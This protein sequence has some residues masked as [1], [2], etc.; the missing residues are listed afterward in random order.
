MFLSNALA[1]RLWVAGFIQLCGTPPLQLLSPR[2]DSG[3]PDHYTD[4]DFDL[5][6]GAIIM[7]GLL[8]SAA[9]IDSWTTVTDVRTWAGV[10]GDVWA[11]VATALG[12]AELNAL[13]LVAG[14]TDE[15]YRAAILGAQP[16]ITPI[17]RVS[18]NLLF[19]GIKA[20]FGLESN[21]MQNPGASQTA[22]SSST[23]AAAPTTIAVTTTPKVRL[24]QV[25]DQAKDQEVPVLSDTII[26]ELRK[27]YMVIFRDAPLELVEVTDS[28]LTAFHYLVEN[29][30]APFTD[31]GVW[32]P[33]G[34]RLER[35]MRFK[36]HFLD[37][38][39]KWR[40][41]ELPGPSCIEVWRKC[42]RVFETAAIMTQAITPAALMRYA[43]RFEER[44]ER[45][46]EA[47]H[48]CVQADT[49][50][51]SEFLVA[52][53]R[54]QEDFHSRH[55]TVS[56]FNTAMP[57]DSVLKEAAD[58]QD[59]WNRELMEPALTYSRQRGSTPAP[60]HQVLTPVVE[61]SAPPTA[62][63]EKRPRGDRA[64]SRT[65]VAQQICHAF[66]RF[67]NGCQ[68]PCPSGRLHACEGC[69]TP[70]VRGIDC[71]F[72]PSANKRAKGGGKGKK[73]KK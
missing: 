72:K 5:I 54:R 41:T 34:A 39:G 14:L 20:K 38:E 15:D 11:R 26:R 2:R 60:V 29:G 65:N 49:R 68:N 42:Y 32:G 37:A 7:S 18:L 70:G 31:F 45:Y 63:R 50:C 67:H 44:C 53:R 43:A 12:D 22:T 4:F 30:L 27:N 28:Q 69:R 33:Y 55:P 51:R 71:C 10:P 46:H 8:P 57:W 64:T 1:R 25:I 13:M 16:A 3:V 73:A 21:I 23:A 58:S 66:S 61:A 59:F 17:Q 52:E 40:T 6:L 36:S 9:V 24:S 56:G 47:W 35:G 62:P 48:L 19:H